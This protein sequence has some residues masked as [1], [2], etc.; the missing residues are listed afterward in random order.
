MHCSFY[1]SYRQ[2][3]GAPED[4][5]AKTSILDKHER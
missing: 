4:D 5:A 2:I 1:A 3:F